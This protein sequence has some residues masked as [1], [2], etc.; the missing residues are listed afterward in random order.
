MFERYIF[1]FHIHD[2]MGWVAPRRI[3]DAPDDLAWA[4]F[5]YQG[6]ASVVGQSYTGRHSVLR[7][8]HALHSV[9][10]LFLVLAAR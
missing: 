3:I 9:S 6:A 8:L 2:L 5:F 7:L 4:L 1:L 10:A